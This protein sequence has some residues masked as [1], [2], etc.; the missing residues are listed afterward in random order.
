MQQLQAFSAVT[1]P[2]PEQPAA[3]RLVVAQLCSGP[4]TDAAQVP[5]DQPW[6]AVKLQPLHP[7]LD[8]LIDRARGGTVANAGRRQLALGG[9][10]DEPEIAEH[11]LAPMDQKRE[12]RDITSQ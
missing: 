3:V 7:E 1:G 10:I 6:R 2:D 4:A 8:R 11:R 5:A 9:A 12:G